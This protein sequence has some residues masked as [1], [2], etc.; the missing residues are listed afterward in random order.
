MSL[1]ASRTPSM[2]DEISG[3][4]AGV[5]DGFDVPDWGCRAVQNMGFANKY[6]STWLFPFQWTLK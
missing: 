3:V 5:D 1:K 2:I 4:Q 6:C